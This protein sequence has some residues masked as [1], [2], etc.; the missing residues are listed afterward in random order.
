MYRPIRT[1]Q[2]YARMHVLISVR[3]YNASIKYIIYSCGSFGRNRSISG[4]GGG[5]GCCGGGSG[6][7]SCSSRSSSIY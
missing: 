7:G 1:K 3:M 2:A 4:G 6:G 5:G